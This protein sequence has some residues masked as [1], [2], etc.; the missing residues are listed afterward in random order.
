MRVCCAGSAGCDSIR[1]SR[2]TCAAA[3]GS[4]GRPTW[5]RRCPVRAAPGS[6]RGRGH[7]SGRRPA[8][9]PAGA[10]PDD[11]RGRL[12][13]RRSPADHESGADT[14]RSLDE[15]RDSGGASVAS[16]APGPVSASFAAGGNPS[17][18]TVSCRS[19][20]N[21]NGRRLV[22]RALTP[23]HASS[24]VASPG[25][26]SRTCS[27]LS[28]SSSTRFPLSRSIATSSGVWLPSTLHRPGRQAPGWR[29]RDRPPSPTGRKRRRRG[30]AAGCRRPRVPAGSCP[31]HRA[32]RE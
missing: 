5:V 25:P 17:G 18:S 6:A 23:G 21:L 11:V 9:W 26:A 22:T 28:M 29:R 32:R 15:Q 31:P 10:R 13:R 19:P 4:P 30:T 3:R 20:R 1:A 14:L 24:R 27:K 16:T 8:R 2:A 7:A 12:S